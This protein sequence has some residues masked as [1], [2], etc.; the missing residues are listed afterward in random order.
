MKC[1]ARGS[2]VNIDNLILV[3]REQKI[4]QRQLGE[5]LNLSDWAITR[6][7]NGHSAFTLNEAAEI[8]HRTGKKTLDELFRIEKSEAL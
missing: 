2:P 8:C 3:M 7:M 1:A 4:T 6:K 5:W